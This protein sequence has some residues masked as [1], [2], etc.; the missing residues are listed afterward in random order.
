MLV[1]MRPQDARYLAIPLPA[2]SSA[3]DATVGCVLMSWPVINPLSR[4]RHAK[5]ALA[6]AN[7]PEWPKSIIPR[8]DAYWRSEA[9]M[10]EGNPMLALERGEKVETPPA[11][12]FQGRGDVLHDYKDADATFPGNEPQRFVANY[13]KAGGEIAVEYIDAERHAGHSP[14]LSNTGDMFERMVVFVYR[15]LK[16][17]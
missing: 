16:V 10:A 13:R 7:P 12:W 6:G 8:Q 5:R 1:A 14:D 4:Y 9:N 11:V 15:H 3:Q 2:G 17:V